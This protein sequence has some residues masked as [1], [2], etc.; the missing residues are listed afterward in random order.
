MH[1]KL[2]TPDELRRCE[3]CG[4]AIPHRFA[5]R[6]CSQACHG[7]SRMQTESDFWARVKKTEDCWLWTGYRNPDGYGVTSW[8]GKL[9]LTHRIAYALT[10]DGIGIFPEAVLHHLCANPLCCNP[11]HLEELEIGN[12]L[13]SRSPNALVYQN[14][15]KTHC[16]HGHEFTP[17]NT[18]VC[19]P[20][21][22]PNPVRACRICRR[23][24]DL[25][26]KAKVREQSKPGG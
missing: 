17:E 8:K 16:K 11:N 21:S 12:H 22:S 6:F 1:G 4:G 9:H 20:P 10:H 5:K 23:I 13:R 3:Y 15:H 14:S 2:I 19:H 7:K 25:K 26:H 18:Y 24:Q